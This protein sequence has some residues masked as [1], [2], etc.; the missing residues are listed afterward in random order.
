MH[1]RRISGGRRQ[2]RIIPCR[3]V[4]RLS[5]LRSDEA[6]ELFSLVQPVI[7]DVEK[8]MG[9]VGVPIGLNDC[10]TAGQTVPYGHLHIIP[11]HPGDVVDP[12]VGIPNAIW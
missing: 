5:E 1:C 6:A 12:R 7:S 3:H 4:A 11:R 9:A 10:P 2:L 8:K